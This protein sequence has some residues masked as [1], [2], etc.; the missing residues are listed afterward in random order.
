MPRVIDTVKAVFG[1]DPSKGV[2]PD[3]AV[4]VGAAIQGGVL[5]GSVT[6]VLLLDVTPLSLGIEVRSFR[7][8]ET[9]HD[10]KC[11]LAKPVPFFRPLVECSPVSSTETPPSPLRN[12]KLSLPLL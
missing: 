1:R 12:P 5:A 10:P 11:R 9:G 2:N 6:D 4:A 3:E 7:S 8:S